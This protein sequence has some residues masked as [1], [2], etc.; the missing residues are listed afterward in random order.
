MVAM[1]ADIRGV[2]VPP[3]VLAAEIRSRLADPLRMWRPNPVGDQARFF[4][5]TESPAGGVYVLS[6]GNRSGKSECGAASFARYVRFGL[7]A[8]ARELAR[9]GKPAQV[10]VIGQNYEMVGTICWREKLS[11]FIPARD[12]DSISWRDQRRGWPAAVRLRNGV[13]ILFKSGDQ[14]REAMQGASILGAWID[15]QIPNDVLEEIRMRC[16]DHAAPIFHTM[17]PLTPD[18]H[19][20]AR[21]E[22]R[23]TVKGWHWYTIDIEDNRRSRGGHLPDDEVDLILA[24][25]REEN[26]D[27]YETRKSG[28]FAALHG[29]IFKAFST[30]THVLDAADM[31]ALI[32]RRRDGLKF[33][34]GIDFGTVNPFCFLLGARDAEGAWYV[35]D[36]HYEAQRTIDHHIIRI[37]RMLDEWE[38]RPGPFFADPG[39]GALTAAGNEFIVSGRKALT[40]AGYHVV[41]ADKRWWESCQHVMRLLARTPLLNAEGKVEH[42]PPRLF[43][44]RRCANLIRQIQTYRYQEGTGTKDPKDQGAV[45]QNDHAVDALRYLL[46]TAH[47]RGLS[48]ATPEPVP[49]MARTFSGGG[50]AAS[51]RG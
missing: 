1:A 6:G 29:V 7:R 34:A 24:Q 15:E 48:A 19:M 42:G 12:I 27:Q 28:H 21:W 49:G 2:A 40:R 20:Q 46:F 11:R 23:G 13:E 8:K 18:P 37:G 47:T 14:G 38:I 50:F 16:V 31:D 22:A 4:R 17:T 43:I 5:D 10:W 25:L 26:P 36:E 41:N 30:T 9:Q 39:D 35:F 44:S 33:A 32:R 3:D 45:K 51:A